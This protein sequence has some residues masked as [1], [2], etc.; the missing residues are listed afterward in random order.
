MKFLLLLLFPMC[1]NAQTF[2][3]SGSDT[4]SVNKISEKIKFEGYSV[5]SD[6]AKADYIIN[7]LIDGAYKY[8]S[9]KRNFQGYITIVD[10]TTGK[11]I[12]KSPVEKASPSVYNG[13]NASYRIFEK[14]AKKYL[15]DEL[16]KCPKTENIPK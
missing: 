16:K 2:F 4:Y 3:I 10:R 12:Y 7:L 15:P 5:T 14:I 1:S 6:S 13:Y 8:V 11:E 9:F